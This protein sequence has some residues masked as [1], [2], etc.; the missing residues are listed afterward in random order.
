MYV[1]RC[2]KVQRAIHRTEYESVPPIVVPEQVAG[3]G[4]VH[5][6]LRKEL[7][8]R[9]TLD[10]ALRAVWLSL[11]ALRIACPF[12]FRTSGYVLVENQEV[13]SFGSYVNQ[14]AGSP[15]TQ[16]R[17]GINQIRD[18]QAVRRAMDRWNGRVHDRARS[19]LVLYSQVA[20]GMA[21]SWQ[22]CI[23][24]LIAS[25]EAFFPQPDAR[26][27]QPH[28]P[29]NEQYGG[30]LERRV[31]AFISGIENVSGTRVWLRNTYARHRNQRSRSAGA[32]RQHDG[33]R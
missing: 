32:P 10:A 33:P 15:R 23:L 4:Q 8:P 13:K 5:A 18:A 11:V 6:C 12:H 27:A 21:Q 24:G 19:G 16:Q 2:D 9:M 22:L 3:I 30:R 26:V 1:D 31:A 14:S 25:F 17:I 20:T 28:I 29:K 7:P